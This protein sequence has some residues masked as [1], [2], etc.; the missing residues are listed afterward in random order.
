MKDDQSASPQTAANSKPKPATAAK[1]KPRHRRVI[2]ALY[3]F[4]FLP[5]ILTALYLYIFAEDQY[6]STMG[7]AVRSQEM[8]SPIDMLGGIANLS[9]STGSDTDILFEFMQSQRLVRSI[10]EKLDLRKMYHMPSDPFFGI[11]NDSS[12]EDLVRYWSRIVKVYYSNTTGLIE[13][14]VTAFKPEDAQ[15]IGQAIYDQSVQMINNLSISARRDA[16]QYAREQLQQAKERL[17]KSREAV[18]QF[19]LRT[20]IVDPE[21][22]ILGRMGVLNSL[23]GQLSSAQIEADILAKTA[24]QGDPRLRQIERR[25]QVIK[26]RLAS[27]RERFS[28]GHGEDGAYAQQVG[29]YERLAVDREF[30]ETAYVAA[31]GALDVAVAEASRKSR[32]LAAYIE[33]TLAETAEHPKRLTIL[34]TLFGFLLAGWAISVMI[35]YSLRDRR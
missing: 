6:A 15:K 22:D 2:Q 21:A 26:E 1:M 7:F 17:K 11:P 25:V 16:T 19:R 10:D 5:S 27:E 8:T 14:R 4:V 34:V 12:I 18:Q 3:L 35:Y 32:Y 31:L 24:G 20:Q 29:E 28:R 33:P 13:V 9:G 23:Q 30:A